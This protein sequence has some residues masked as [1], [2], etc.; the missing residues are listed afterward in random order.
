MSIARLTGEAQSVSRDHDEYLLFERTENLLDKLSSWNS[1]RFGSDQSHLFG[2]GEC[3][4]A[5]LDLEA[6]I[7]PRKQVAHR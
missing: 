1:W 4:R 7:G 3:G 5:G 6:G 2:F